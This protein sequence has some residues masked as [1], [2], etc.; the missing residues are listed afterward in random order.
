MADSAS[1]C[2]AMFKLLH[3]LAGEVTKLST[4]QPNSET[5]DIQIEDKLVL[6]IMKTHSSRRKKLCCGSNKS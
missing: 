5:N 3:I 1:Y 2:K 6:I 4:I